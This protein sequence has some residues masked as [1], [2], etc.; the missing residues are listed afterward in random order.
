MILI[1][2]P[3]LPHDLKLQYQTTLTTALSP[4]LSY[5]TCTDVAMCFPTYRTRPVFG[6]ANETKQKK[7]R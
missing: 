5:C 6:S 2:A 1:S 3:T 4:N 7:I